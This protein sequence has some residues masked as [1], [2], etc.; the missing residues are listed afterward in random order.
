MCVSMRGKSQLKSHDETFTLRSWPPSMTPKMMDAMVKPS[1]HPLALTSWDGGKSSV[2][3]PYL[4]GEY[5]A[6]PKPTTA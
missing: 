6:A 3:M 5:A 2:K 1:I 4:A